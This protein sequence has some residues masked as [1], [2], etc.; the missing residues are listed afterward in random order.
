MCGTCSGGNIK[1]SFGLGSEYIVKRFHSWALSTPQIDPNRLTV[2]DMMAFLA[3]DP[4]YRVSGPTARKIVTESM[5]K[6]RKG[7]DV[8]DSSSSVSIVST[9]GSPSPTI[10]E[11]DFSAFLQAYHEISSALLLPLRITQLPDL[12]FIPKPSHV[13]TR[14]IGSWVCPCLGAAVLMVSQYANYLTVSIDSLFV[15]I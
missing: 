3:T 8:G 13:P 14:Y 4:Q 12:N 2:D 9:E 7:N 10:N 6:L 5:L 11:D 15:A 1:S